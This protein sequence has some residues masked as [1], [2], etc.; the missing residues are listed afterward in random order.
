METPPPH[1]RLYV[2]AASD[3]AFET[4]KMPMTC[5]HCDPAPCIAACIPEAMHRSAGDDLKVPPNSQAGK[6]LRLKGRGIPARQAG[7]LYVVLQ[8]ALPPADSEEHRRMYEKMKQ[9][10]TFNP[11]ASLEG[12][13]HDQQH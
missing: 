10:F 11:R 5:R 6:K 1:P 7:D 9:E 3:S 8:I 12:V 2:E 4:T 13:S